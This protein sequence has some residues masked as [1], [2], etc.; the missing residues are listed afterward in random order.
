MLTH[1][2]LALLRGV[3]QLPAYVAHKKGFFARE[4]IDSQVTISPT[5]WL[6]PEQLSSGA[7]DFAV[8]PWTRVA[9]TERGE[10]P[11]KV[12]CGSGVDEAA[13]VV[14]AGIT[15]DEV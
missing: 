10:A 8:I 12:L 2:R 14:R 15:V 3:C 5:A 7:A 11:L 4:E 13:I 6:I 1:V 9:A